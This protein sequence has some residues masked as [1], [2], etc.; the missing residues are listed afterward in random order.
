M[1]GEVILCQLATNPRSAPLLKTPQSSPIN[2][3]FLDSPSQQQLRQTDLTFRAGKLPFACPRPPI[4]SRISAMTLR[5]RSFSYLSPLTP[6]LSTAAFEP[7]STGANAQTTSAKP[8]DAYSILVAQRRQRPVAPHL[9]IYKPQIT[10]YGSGLNRITASILSGGFY[11]FGAAYLVSPLV[12]WHLE[13]A[14]MAEWFGSFSE[15]SKGLMK[16]TI[17]LPFTYHC[18]NGVRHLIW[19]SGREFGNRQVQVTG[20]ICVGLTV[21]SSA[22]LAII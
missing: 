19:D 11:I 5:P 21:V 13:S 15:L 16:G 14:S 6:H 2:P 3:P 12:G 7:S 20:W 17:S 22:I 9:S 1:Q 8:S 18:W 10:W 4:S